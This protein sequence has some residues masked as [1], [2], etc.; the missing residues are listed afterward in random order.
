MGAGE[1][2]KITTDYIL[3]AIDDL[4]NGSIPQD[5]ADIDFTGVILGTEN[6]GNAT[7]TAQKLADNSSWVVAKHPWQRQLRRTSPPQ[8]HHRLRLRLERHSLGRL[9]GH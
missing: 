4:P 7:V 2:K 9:H 8:H 3:G 6:Y 5:K 1:T